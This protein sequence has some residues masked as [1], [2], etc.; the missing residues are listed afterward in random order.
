MFSG[1]TALTTISLPAIT[2]IGSYTFRDC[3]AL[4]TVS[5]G[6][7]VTTLRANTFATCTALTSVTIQ[8]TSAPTV[9]NTTF[10]STAAGL[11]I[12]VPLG[13]VET[14]Q[15]ANIWKDNYVSKI[16]AIPTT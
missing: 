16:Q 14:Y 1:C 5:L 10:P 4:A 6:P 15:V 11:V 13:S 12:Y 2:S 7:A 3:T 9:T 8:A